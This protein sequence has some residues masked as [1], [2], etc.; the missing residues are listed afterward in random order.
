MIVKQNVSKKCTVV[1]KTREL[2]IQKQY[3]YKIIKN[4][5]KKENEAINDKIIGDINTL[6][7]PEEEYYK[8]V[9]VSYFSNNN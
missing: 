8:R 6:F 4:I 5:R 3:E 2:K 7:E 1:R 9:R